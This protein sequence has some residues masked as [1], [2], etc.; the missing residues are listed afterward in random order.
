MAERRPSVF[1]G[2]ST[3]GLAV[4]EAIQVNL[5]RACEV[6]VWSQGLFGLS[7]G[8]LETLVD[9]AQE[10]DFAAL[11]LTPDDMIHSRKKDQ[12]SPR[13]NV[14]LELGLFIGVLGRKRTFVVFDRSADIKLPS[15]TAGV[16]LA[17]YQ[18]HAAGNFQSAVPVAQRS[19]RRSRKWGCVHDRNLV[20]TLTRTPTSKSFA[21]CWM[22]GRGSFSY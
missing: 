1:I 11:V 12:Q 15:D 16:T 18:P 13:D 22:R 20:S 8:T 19:R 2:S 10:F 5:D 4:A 17:S 14:I 3:E 21:I 9:R 7:S 6:A